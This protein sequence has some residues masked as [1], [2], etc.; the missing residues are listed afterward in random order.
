MTIPVDEMVLDLR[1]VLEK[2]EEHPCADT[3]D[4]VIAETNRIIH[5][6]EGEFY[7]YL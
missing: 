3:F 5:T 4:L 1:A 7:E 2:F 6:C